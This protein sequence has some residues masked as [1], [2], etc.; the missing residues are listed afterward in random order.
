MYKELNSSS[1]SHKW[2]IRLACG[3]KEFRCHRIVLEAASDYLSEV[4]RDAFRNYD[5]KPVLHEGQWVKPKPKIRLDDREE[6]LAPTAIECIHLYWYT[7]SLQ[8]CPEGETSFNI[9][10]NLALDVLIAAS[11]FR[12]SH[13]AEKLVAETII[14]QLKHD[15]ASNSFRNAQICIEFLSISFKKLSNKRH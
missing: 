15:A 10:L 14:P 12:M 1:A 6:P 13:L 4:I 9:S 2:D 11:F 7:G 5:D 3:P 8:K